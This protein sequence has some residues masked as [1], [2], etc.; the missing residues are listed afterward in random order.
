MMGDLKKVFFL[1]L[2]FESKNVSY[3]FLL[4]S[5]ISKIS[6]LFLLLFRNCYL[7]KCRGFALY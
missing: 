2:Y 1:M 6:L 4:L 7:K 3:D 5:S